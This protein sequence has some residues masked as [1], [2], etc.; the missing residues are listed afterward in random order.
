[1]RIAVT[2]VGRAFGRQSRA[3]AEYR[4]FSSLARFGHVVHEADVSLVPLALGGS[5]AR[6][7]VAVTLEDGRRMRVPPAMLLFVG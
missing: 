4:V 2:A 5:T 6:C 7:T 3:Y 1:M